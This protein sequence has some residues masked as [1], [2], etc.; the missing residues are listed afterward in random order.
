MAY[1]TNSNLTGLTEDEA[2]EF[3]RMYMN[4]MKLFL[5]LAAVAHAIVWYYVPWFPVA[6]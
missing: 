3:H 5:G 4:G 6:G 1:S 2:K